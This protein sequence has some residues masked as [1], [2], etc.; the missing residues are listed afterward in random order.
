MKIQ[1]TG[2]SGFTGA[3]FVLEQGL[4]V[5][6]N[7]APVPL[8]GAVNY[9]LRRLELPPVPWPT[10]TRRSTRDCA[11]CCPAAPGRPCFAWGWR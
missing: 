11:S 2:A 1:V 4:S 7:G 3:G 6:V 9:V 8:W 10:V 5:R